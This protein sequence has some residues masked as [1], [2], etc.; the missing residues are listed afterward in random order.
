LWKGHKVW[1]LVFQGKRESLLDE[2]AVSLVEYL[3]KN[4][5]D[6][7]IHATELEA[8]VDGV[9]VIG[10]FTGID[11]AT[12]ISDLA[13]GVGGVIHEATGKKLT[14]GVGAIL[15]KKLA[16]LSADMENPTLTASQR[17][18]AK[19]ERDALLKANARGGRVTGAASQ[20]A[21]RVRKAL[22]RFIAELKKAEGRKGKPNAVLRAFGEHL[23]RHLRLPS[24]G[25][26]GRAGASGRPGCFTYEPPTGAVWKD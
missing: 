2:R 19:G 5:P 10:R 16:D 7:P 21:E 11:R 18:E 1:T 15:K 13:G 8:R 20:S 6:E 25:A 12:G 24:M 26:K 9:P 17:E 4:P 14:G 23:D 3:L 22:N